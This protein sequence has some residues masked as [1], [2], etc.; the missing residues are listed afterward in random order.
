LMTSMEL[1]TIVQN[2]LPIVIIVCND[3]ALTS[4]R[5]SQ[6]HRFGATLGVDVKNPD[7][8]KYANS[9][10][11]E[12]LRIEKRDEFYLALL[13]AMNYNKPFLMELTPEVFR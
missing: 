4:I 8:V 3:N 13:E 11:I 10:D 2:N 5:W 1:S 6:E 12:A 9:F 7:F